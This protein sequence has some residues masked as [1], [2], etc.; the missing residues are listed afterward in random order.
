MFSHTVPA[1]SV[2]GFGWD[3]CE[4][5]GWWNIVKEKI[6]DIQAAGFTHVWLPPPS[7]SVAPQASCRSP[8]LVA[9]LCMPRTLSSSKPV[10]SCVLMHAVAAAAA[11]YPLSGCA[12]SSA[13]GLLTVHPSR[14]PGCCNTLTCLLLQGYLPSQLYKLDSKFGNKEELAALTQVRRC[15][16]GHFTGKPCLAMLNTQSNCLTAHSGGSPA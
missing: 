13:L 3:A 14:T 10:S 15:R 2:A 11:E 12:A 6:P 5:G 16:G 4:K 7:A 1:A 8:A 9:W